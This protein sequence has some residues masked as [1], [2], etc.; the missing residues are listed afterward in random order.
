M[1]N[2]NGIKAKNRIWL[3][4]GAAGYGNGWPWEKPF[5][6]LGLIDFSAFGAV[7][8]RTLTPEPRRGNYTDP[9]EFE[10]MSLMSHLCRILSKDR[11]RVLRKIPGGWLNNMGWWNVG[12]D[13]WIEN[14][15]PSLGEVAIIPNIGGFSIE[16]YLKLIEK[17]NPLNVTAVEINISCPN[18]E[19]NYDPPRDLPRLFSEAKRI[20]R[21][22]L[23]LK[24]GSSEKD[25]G[26]AQTAAACGFNAISLINSVPGVIVTKEGIF[27]G[28]Q[29]G[30]R[31]KETALNA[32]L[33]LKEALE[34]TKKPIIAGGGI[35]S[36][37]DCQNFFEVGADAVT[38]GSGFLSPLRLC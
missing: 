33:K 26:F 37:K 6:K 19:I 1:I 5:I 7:A 38:L 35:A 10:R 20:S 3:A 25:I 30:P 28:G 17:L 12:I 32:V 9:F 18:V 15:Y 27:T 4:A 14:I 16:E 2:L 8:T 13:Y 22:P 36:W 21:H 23:I 29:S 24:I 11:K 31:I 34:I